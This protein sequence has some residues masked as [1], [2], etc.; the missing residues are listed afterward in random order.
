MNFK[1][2]GIG[3]GGIAG[4]ALAVVG[5]ALLYDVA[6]RKAAQRKGDRAPDLAED[7]PR[8]GPDDRA[9]DAFRPDP[10]APVPATERDALAPATIPVSEPLDR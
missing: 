8:P 7:A 5:G 1:R 10:T 3:L 6:T 4:A 9:P 2:I